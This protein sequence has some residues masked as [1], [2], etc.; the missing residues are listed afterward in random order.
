M[1]C[2]VHSKGQPFLHDA[3]VLRAAAAGKW[4]CWSI[5]VECPAEKRELK[6]SQWNL[7]RKILKEETESGMQG[8]KKQ[9]QSIVGTKKGVLKSEY[10][11]YEERKSSWSHTHAKYCF[12]A[13]CKRP[14]NSPILFPRGLEPLLWKVIGRFLITIKLRNSRPPRYLHTHRLLYLTCTGELVKWQSSRYKS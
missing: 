1:I 10:I 5:G 7:K 2:V 11:L 13:I 3:A 6:N 9:K 4:Y 12:Q 8:R 14:K